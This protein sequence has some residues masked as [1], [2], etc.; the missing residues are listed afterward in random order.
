MPHHDD[1]PRNKYGYPIK[2]PTKIAHYSEGGNVG[3]KSLLEETSAAL[4]RE[5]AGIK[6]V[7]E[8]SFLDSVVDTIKKPFQGKPKVSGDPGSTVD[9]IN[10]ANKKT[11]A[12]IDSIGDVSDMNEQAKR[13]GGQIK[14]KPR[15][16]GLAARGHG[17]AMGR[18]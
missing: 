15:G 13:K 11:K 18:K 16:V 8:P 12:Y 2:K 4:A 6:D 3:K 5:K 10:T 14:S 7:P 1:V 17:K 9:K